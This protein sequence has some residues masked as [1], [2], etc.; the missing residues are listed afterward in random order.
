MVL[1]NDG[2]VFATGR[3]N[4]GQLGNGQEKDHN[5]NYV[6]VFRNAIAIAAG[7]FHSMVLKKDG[8]VWATGANDHGQLGDGSKGDRSSY[9]RVFGT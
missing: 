5:T 6:E 1:K 7:G 2:T 8:T 9:A 4:R 3:N